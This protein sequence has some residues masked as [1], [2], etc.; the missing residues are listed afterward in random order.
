MPDNSQ[1]WTLSNTIFCVCNDFVFGRTI[2]I[3]LRCI[4]PY[5][6]NYNVLASGAWSMTSSNPIV[7]IPSKRRFGLLKLHALWAHMAGGNFHR[8]SDATDSPLAQL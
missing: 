8:F 7:I 1:S 3:S 4:Y 6:D 2:W 5:V